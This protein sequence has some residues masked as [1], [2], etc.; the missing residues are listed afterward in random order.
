MEDGGQSRQTRTN[1]LGIGAVDPALAGPVRV[2]PLCGSKV[3]SIDSRVPRESGRRSEVRGQKP[4]SAVRT[5][6]VITGAVDYDAVVAPTGRRGFRGE[7]ASNQQSAV[8][9]QQS[10][11]ADIVN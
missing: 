3:T 5:K 10:A 6:P 2:S 9:S 11:V 1:P 8:S 7:V 4:H